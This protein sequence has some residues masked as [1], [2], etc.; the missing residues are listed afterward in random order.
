MKLLAVRRLFRIQRVIIRYQLDDL[1]LALP[2][3]VWLRVLSALLPW[4]WLP[5]RE[6]NLS[7]G[8]RLRLA[9]EELGPIFI[10]FGQLL[11][12][13]RDLLP[14]DIAD[15]LA[16]LRRLFELPDGVIYMDGNSL[17]ALPRSV[18]PRLAEVIEQTTG[19]GN[20]D[21]HALLQRLGIDHDAVGLLRP[22][23]CRQ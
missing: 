15:E 8:A 19:R 6:L 2:V 12:T 14:A 10:K 16:P 20:Q 23:P 22:R 5:R 4:R 1:L 18:K 11:S 3:P 17:G 9:L 13:R 7:R 21:V